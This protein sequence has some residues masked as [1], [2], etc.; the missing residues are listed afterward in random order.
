MLSLA[1]LLLAVPIAMVLAEEEPGSRFLAAGLILLAILTDF[2]DGLIARKLNQVTEFGKII[3]PLADKIA[4]GVVAWVLAA[5]GKL[6]V[7]FLVSVLGRDGLI[8][9]GGIYLRRARGVVLQ[10]NETG[11]WAVTCLAALI[12]FTILELPEALWIN[13]FLLAA[14]TGLLVLSFGLYLRRFLEVSRREGVVHGHS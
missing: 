14:S 5:K 6:P 3:D 9:L 10:S 7:W 8:L 2:F 13:R 1:R 12:L 4:V 11:K